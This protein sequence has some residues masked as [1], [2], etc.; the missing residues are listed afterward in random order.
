MKKGSVS[1]G[2]VYHAG[3]PNA[4]EDRQALPV[5]LESLIVKHRTSTYL[6]R[7]DD[8]GVAELG[9][10]PGSIVVVDRAIEPRHGDKIVAVVEGDFV[11]RIYQKTESAALFTPGGNRE[12]SDNVALWGVVTYVIQAMRS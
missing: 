7:L 2:V 1:D 10:G 4:G 11:V 12:E 9:W 6:W 3:F 5:G 8:E